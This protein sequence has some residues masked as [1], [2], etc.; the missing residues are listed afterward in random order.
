MKSL[1]MSI[2]EHQIAIERAA[3][4]PTSGSGTNF[5]MGPTLVKGFASAKGQTQ[6]V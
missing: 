1:L 3:L 4:L 5:E 2:L 6:R